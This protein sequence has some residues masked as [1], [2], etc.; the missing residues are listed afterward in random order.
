MVAVGFEKVECRQPV[1]VG[2][3][4]SFFTRVERIDRTS[5]TVHVTVESDRDNKVEQLIETEVTYE[6]VRLDEQGWRPVSIRG[7]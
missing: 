6:T 1:F 7:E 3:V 4:L 2:D 5:I